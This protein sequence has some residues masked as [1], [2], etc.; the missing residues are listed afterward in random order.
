MTGEDKPKALAPSMVAAITPR[1]TVKTVQG[2]GSRVLHLFE[3]VDCSFCRTQEQELSKVRNV[4][5]YRH[6]LPGHDAH[7][8]VVAANVLCAPDPGTQWSRAV[9]GMAIVER[10]CPGD[11]LDRNYALAKEIGIVGTPSTVFQNG[12]VLGGLLDSA[13]IEKLLG[14]K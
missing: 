14:S 12:R 3:S 9:A 10:T 13:R 8:R 2:D 5:I 11:G 7:A 4:T 6:L 1:D